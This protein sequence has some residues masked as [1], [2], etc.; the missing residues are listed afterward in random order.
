[1]HIR[2]VRSVALA[3]VALHGCGA[4]A[5]D[6]IDLR[7]IEPIHG[8]ADAGKSK[9]TVCGAC[10]GADGIAAVPTFPNLAGQSVDY[11]YWALVE[12]RRA[13][14]ADSP[15]TA[16]VAPLSDGD[17]RDVAAYFAALPAESH[18]ASTVAT[19]EDVHAAGLFRNGDPSRGIPPCQGCHGHDAGGHPEADS[20]PML[21]GY[22]RLRGQ[23]AAHI[24]QRLRN[25]RNGQP[26][27][28]SNDRVM[29]GIAAT[30]DDDAITAISEWLQR[31]AP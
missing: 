4:L 30:L 9:A 28:S 7:R 13:A 11:L 8:D 22:P 27:L 21:R 24:A 6:F 29:S 5:A 15:M 2:V 12:F 26:S 18:S 19:A 14:R 1:M 16:Q 17:L 23:H 31:G 20:K 25:W 3:I 10:H